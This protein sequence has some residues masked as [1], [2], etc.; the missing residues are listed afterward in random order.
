MRFSSLLNVAD[1]P[2]EIIRTIGALECCNS[3]HG[4]RSRSAD[5]KNKLSTIISK[6]NSITQD[7]KQ[8]ILQALTT[9]T[10][11]LRIGYKIVKWDILWK[12]EIEK[13]LT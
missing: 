7:K 10:N 1:E 5:L 3:I 11:E 2:I 6:K 9:T 8:E 13:V 12:L 4:I